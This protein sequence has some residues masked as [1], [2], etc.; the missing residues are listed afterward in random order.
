MAIGYSIGIDPGLNGGLALI[1]DGKL[2]AYNIM[3]TVKTQK[4]KKTKRVI[5][6]PEI[7]NLIYWWMYR[8][9]QQCDCAIAVIESV[10]AMPKQGVTSMFSFG[11]GYGRCLGVLDAMFCGMYEKVPPQTWKKILKT[12]DKQ[13]AI[14]YVKERFPGCS[15]IAPKCRT[16]HDGMADAICIADYAYKVHILKEPIGNDKSKASKRKRVK[17]TVE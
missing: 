14:D 8:E 2:V 7:V 1:V 17:K 9:C 3:P 6:G 11:E 13:G 16:P 5:D 12:T 4:G 10:H 15:L